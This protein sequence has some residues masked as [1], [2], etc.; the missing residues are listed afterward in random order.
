MTDSE[1]CSNK[2]WSEPHAMSD[3]S[4]DGW[5]AATWGLVSVGAWGGATEWSRKT[6]AEHQWASK[7][8]RQHRAQVRWGEPGLR[9]WAA[10]HCELKVSGDRDIDDTRGGRSMIRVHVLTRCNRTTS[11]MR[12][13]SPK[14][15]SGDS[16]RSENAQTHAN[17]HTIQIWNS[18]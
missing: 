17:K 9:C 3:A 1:F 12:G 16:R 8:E 11:K 7:W 4:V 6:E 18:S 2:R 13:L 15:I 14:I 10:A 5:A